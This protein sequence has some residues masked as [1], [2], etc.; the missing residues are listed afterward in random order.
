MVS[1]LPCLPFIWGVGSEYAQWKLS[2]SDFGDLRCPRLRVCG[3][4]CRLEPDTPGG[5]AVAV[6]TVPELFP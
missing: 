6:R 3:W 2:V 5:K 1:A 4:R